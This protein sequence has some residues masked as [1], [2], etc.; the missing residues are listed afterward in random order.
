MISANPF[1][2]S[3]EPYKITS[4]EIWLSNAPKNIIKL[5]WNESNI[6]FDF[7]KSIFKEYVEIPGG[8]SWY[9]DCI[10]VELSEVL[11]N[12]LKLSTANILTYPGSDVA[13]ESICRA[14][15]TL[16]TNVYIPMPTYENF[17]VYCYQSG[18]SVKKDVQVFPFS[19]VMSQLEKALDTDTQYKLV[20][21]VNPNNPCGY[22]IDQTFIRSLLVKYPHTLFVIDEAY[23]EFSEQSSMVSHVNQYENLIVTRTFSKAFGLAGMRLGYVCAHTSIINILAKIRNGKN[24]QMLSQKLGICALQNIDKI[25]CWIKEVKINRSMFED[26]C[27][28]NDVPYVSSNGNFVLFKAKETDQ[29]CQLLKAENIFVRNRHP[30]IEHCIRVTIGTEQEIYYFMKILDKYMKYIT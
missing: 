13:L 5:D 2:E 26:W 25:N 14:Y 22:F 23:I 1:I 17:F 21:L 9:P 11:S 24:V 15:L 8:I 6:D 20:Y 4:Q 29:L 16:H 10:S 27:T 30:N 18:A 3:L 7:Y 12:Y 19:N 28:S